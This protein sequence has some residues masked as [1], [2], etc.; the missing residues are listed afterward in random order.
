M[1]RNASSV[2]VSIKMVMRVFP[3]CDKTAPRLA[4]RK[5]YVGESFL[6]D[7]LLILSPFTWLCGTS[8]DESNILRRLHI[9]VGDN[10]R[11]AFRSAPMVM[12]RCSSCRLSSSLRRW[13]IIKNCRGIAEA[14][15]MLPHVG[16]CLCRILQHHMHML[17][18][19]QLPVNFMRWRVYYRRGPRIGLD[20]SVTASAAQRPVAVKLRA[21]AMVRHAACSRRLR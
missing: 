6:L 4:S 14:H 2:S 5:S 9:G 12:N 3:L 16:T 19:S 10:Q 11:M 1:A 8:R 15:A 17:C 21:A 7:A 13:G 18:I 20:G